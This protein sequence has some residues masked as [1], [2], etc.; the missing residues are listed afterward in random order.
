MIDPVT[1]TTATYN[2]LAFAK[3]ALTTVLGM[4]MDARAREK[5]LAAEASLG[6]AQDILFNLRAEVSELQQQNTNLRRQLAKREI[7]IACL[8]AY[9]I[10]KTPGGAIVYASK[11][12]LKHYAC[13]TCIES[14]REIQVLQDNS[15]ETGEFTCPSCTSA[16]RVRAPEGETLPPSLEPSSPSLEPSSPSLE[17]PY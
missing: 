13:P 17:P 2:G 16:F 7:W 4:K 9:D 12:S 6:E 14:K 10:V 5:V 3:D 1:A 15:D 8:A 11:S